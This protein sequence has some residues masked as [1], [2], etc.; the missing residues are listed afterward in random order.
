MSNNI[1]PPDMEALKAK[2]KDEDLENI[3]KKIEEEDYPIQYAIGNVPFLDVTI[4]VDER[5]LIPRF[6]TE[7]LVH[8]LIKYIKDNK[9]EKTRCVDICSGSGC[10]GI[11]LKNAFSECDITLIDKSHE[12]LSLAKE[13]AILNNVDL[14]FLECDILNTDLDGKYSI[15]ISN[16]PYV[17]LDEEVSENTKYEPAMALYPGEDELLFY[18][19]I[20]EISK[21]H[22]TENFIIAFEIGALQGEKLKTLAKTHFPNSR[23]LLEKDYEN[24]DRYVFIFGKSE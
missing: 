17:R 8:K 10:I 18:K 5:A 1:T 20:L 11:A 12:A 13:N 23:I 3:I 14:E 24:F 21:N 19:R 2:Y 15:I 6:A 22:V 4:N 16:P 7:L 9:L